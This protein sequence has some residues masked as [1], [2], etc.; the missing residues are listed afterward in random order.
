MLFWKT[1]SE[2]QYKQQ[3]RQTLIHFDPH[4]NR[5]KQ[6]MQQ[7]TFCTSRLPRALNP[8]G[9]SRVLGEPD[10]EADDSERSES[11]AHW[12]SPSIR[13]THRAKRIEGGNQCES[14]ADCDVV[15]NSSRA[16][17]HPGL[18]DVH[19]DESLSPSSFADETR[20]AI[21]HIDPVIDDAAGD[22]IGK[23]EE[24]LKMLAAA[25]RH[26][27]GNEDMVVGYAVQR[28]QSTRHRNAADICLGYAAL[29]L[30]AARH[31]ESG[32]HTGL[33]AYAGQNGE[34]EHNRGDDSNVDFEQ[35]GHLK[36]G[37][38]EEEE[39]VVGQEGRKSCSDNR[40]IDMTI[41]GYSG[42]S[43]QDLLE[44]DDPQDTSSDETTINNDDSTTRDTAT[45]DTNNKDKPSSE[46]PKKPEKPPF[47]YN[48]LIMMAIRSSPEK[49]LTLSQ[50]YEFITKNFPYYKDNKQGWQNSI[51]HNLSL[52][53]CFLKV[54]RHYDDPGKGNYW[55][56]DPSCDDV[57]IGGTTGK[58]RRRSSSASRN[59]LAAMKRVAL[60]Y[61]GYPG[62]YT[63][64]DRLAAFQ[65][66]L[67]SSGYAFPHSALGMGVG[68]GS[69]LHAHQ[70][71]MA[72]AAAA[73]AA[74]AAASQ[75]H[76]H[77]HHSAHR[78]HNLHP[79]LG[80]SAGAPTGA[81]FSQSHGLLSFSIDK[82]LSSDSSMSK[83]AAA[84][85]LAFSDIRA[86][87]TGDNSQ[88]FGSTHTDGSRNTRDSVSSP[89]SG[90]SD[91]YSG[92]PT[93]HPSNLS[94]SQ[95]SLYFAFSNPA[96]IPP[97][98]HS[99]L[100]GGSAVTEMYSRLRAASAF[101][102][103]PVGSVFGPM[104]VG[105][106]GHAKIGN[107]LR[108]EPRTLIASPNSSFTPVVTHNRTS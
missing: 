91:E 99:H 75:Q 80:H 81:Q 105:E 70:I 37:G 26:D 2:T 101:S 10:W 107:S 77:G 92:G 96:L 49:R 3:L 90:H 79:L 15:E 27:P 88:R 94:T 71:S 28:G 45:K 69:S 84:S 62:Y 44:D 21:D 106:V 24:R 18:A 25:G 1:L 68:M 50:I 73:A 35:T 53:K 12:L 8:F 34:V 11:P 76:T 87:V 60:V 98:A 83:A 23:T 104:G 33:A 54:P 6:N 59:R 46:E 74:A 22:I 102:S 72:S 19:S 7:T 61:P 66:A 17:C 9:I 97:L 103:L 14:H 93:R 51:R 39:R 100:P 57:F 13:S 16:E 86:G 30:Q 40:A 67:S 58:L 52:N 41:S 31:L 48:A 95:S 36:L 89:E 56:L 64:Q 42:D 29:K 47:S 63:A 43:P 4:E 78:A 20:M 85:A 108:V 65:L 55:M 82:L 32:D 38:D 5:L